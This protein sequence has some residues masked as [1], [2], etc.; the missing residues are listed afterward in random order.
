[1]GVAWNQ[2]GRPW[3]LVSICSSVHITYAWALFVDYD[4]V[5]QQTTIV[6]LTA[7]LGRWL[8]IASLIFAATAAWIPVWVNVGRMRTHLLMWPQQLILFIGSVAVMDIT[9]AGSYFDGTVKDSAYIFSDQC[10]IVYLMV[11]H[12]VAIIRNAEIANGA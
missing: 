5:S 12:V 3:L 7:V 2:I 10:V 1:M 11:G 4:N 9:R 8:S 6:I